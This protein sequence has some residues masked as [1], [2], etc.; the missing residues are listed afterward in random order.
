MTRLTVAAALGLLL[1]ALATASRLP[2]FDPDEGYYPATAAESV[3][4][5]AWWDL[6]FNGEPRWEKPVLAYALIEGSFSVF[7][8]SAAAA[9]LPSALEGAGLIL[10]TGLIVS[11]LAGRRAGDLSAIVLASTIGVQFFARAAH[12]E[13]ALVLSM[14]VTE[15]LVVWWLVSPPAERPRT[16]PF[17]IGLSLGYGLLAKGPVAAVVP[18]LGA[19]CVAPF[20]LSLRDRWR[21]MLIDALTAASVALAIAAPWFI[22]MTMRHGS[23]FLHDALWTQNVGRFAGEMEH[24]QSSAAFFLATIIGVIP[25]A[26][27]LPAAFWSVRR[28][29]GERRDAVRFAFA[30]IAVTSLLFY[31]LSASK[32]VSYSL[33]L[34]PPLAIVVGMYLDD[35]LYEG[36]ARA[37]AAFRATSAGLALAGLALLALP[38]LRGNTL[39][40]RD[41]IGGVPSN[42]GASSV[43]WLIGPM[44]FVLLL[45]AVLVLLL[46]VRRRVG[47]LY[48][49]G[50]AAPLALLLS[51]GP[52]VDDAYPWRRFGN[53]ISKIGGPAW[54]QM[55]RVPSLTFYAGRP[56]QRLRDDAELE[57]VLDRAYTGWV[58]LGSDWAAKPLL[59]ERIGSGTA[60]IVERSARL[61]LVRLERPGGR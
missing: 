32:L 10:L 15:M 40:M 31:S 41:L 3:D 1:V 23:T 16:L 58:I 42:Q 28:P 37:T 30:A 22:A 21:P 53:E 46:P 61:I 13:I 60:S 55:Y 39:R 27:F 25:W 9:R 29:R 35:A 52:L 14:A 24:G 38:L 59:A 49:V 51:A 33:A 44:A 36:R 48:G 47:A 56:V 12:P 7:G 2:L 11:K 4:A 18:G 45:G 26:G 34:V 50:L 8:R 54:I 17:L 5:G 20:V 43:W 19:I 6:R 57:L